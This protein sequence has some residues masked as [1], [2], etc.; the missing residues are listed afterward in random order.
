[1]HAAERLRNQREAPVIGAVKARE[2]VRIEQ[3]YGLDGTALQR[4]SRE[5]RMIEKP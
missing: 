5:R 4:R 3:E 1:M 2:Y